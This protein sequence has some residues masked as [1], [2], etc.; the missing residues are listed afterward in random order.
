MRVLRDDLRENTGDEEI[1]W[2]FTGLYLGVQRCCRTSFQRSRVA[3]F[4]RNTDSSQD[5]RGLIGC[6]FKSFSNSARMKTY[7]ND[8]DFL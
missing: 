2:N 7:G 4:D 1:H 8:I 5:F 6:L 3:Q